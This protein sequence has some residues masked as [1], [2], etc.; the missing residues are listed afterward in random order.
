MRTALDKFGRIV[1]P[2]PARIA[3]NLDPGDELEVLVNNGVLELRPISRPEA[4]SVRS[5]LPIYV[6]PVPEDVGGS[7]E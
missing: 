5:G 4:F 3:L 7:A 1:V 2:K 6:G